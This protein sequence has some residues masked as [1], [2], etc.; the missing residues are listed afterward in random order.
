[1]VSNKVDL[2]KL[3]S[4]SAKE[5]VEAQFALN[6]GLASILAEVNEEQQKEQQKALA[7]ELLTLLKDGNNRVSSLKRQMKMA[8][9][10]YFKAVRQLQM[11]Q[12]ALD[13][14]QTNPLPL[15]GLLGPYN[16]EELLALLAEASGTD[17]FNHEDFQ[18][19]PEMVKA[20]KEQKGI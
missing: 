2:D 10:A 7:K 15:V 17:Q 8:Q 4:N 9:E 18:V 19:N 6:E 16:Y 1:M 3:F 14:A 5:D 20:W 13:H 11:H 12:F